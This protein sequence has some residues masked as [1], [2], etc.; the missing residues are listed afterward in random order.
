MV[1]RRRSGP[2][3]D[4]VCGWRKMHNDELLKLYFSP[5]RMIK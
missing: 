3:R 4:E 5:N 2:E 1:L